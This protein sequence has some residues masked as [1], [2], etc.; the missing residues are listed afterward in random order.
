MSHSVAVALPWGQGSV[1]YF[2]KQAARRLLVFVHGFGG[3]ASATWAGTASTL[4][5]DPR[6]GT[7][8]PAYFGC[9]SFRT[10]PEMSA[11]ILRALLDEAAGASAEWNAHASRALGTAVAREYEEV[12]VIAHSVGALVSRRR[13]LMQTANGQRGRTR[14]GCRSLHPRT[15]EPFSI[16]FARRW[17]WSRV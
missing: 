7:C 15:W 13:C 10:Q 14:P 2:S 12:L 16:N 9:R 11:G 8:D 1:G 17:G 3:K 6:A 5:T 4:A